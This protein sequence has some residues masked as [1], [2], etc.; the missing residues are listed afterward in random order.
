MTLMVGTPRTALVLPSPVGPLHLAARAEGLTHVTFQGVVRSEGDGSEAGAAVLARAV[1]ELEAY[2]AGE[3]R[4]FTVPVVPEGTPFQQEVWRA[5]R[6]IPYGETISY[7]EQAR[8]VGR[9]TGM[10]AVG[11]ANGRNPVPI[12]IPCHRVIGADGRLVG[13]GGGLET[14]QALLT[15]EGWRP[16]A[17][18]PGQLSLFE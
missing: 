13:F 2:F 7:Q 3:L 8:R 5:L 15:L 14:K 18:V 10:R 11:A 1:A 16:P 6:D 17:A 4:T 12:I 9:P